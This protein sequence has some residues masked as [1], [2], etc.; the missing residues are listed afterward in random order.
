MTDTRSVELWLDV[1]SAAWAFDDG[2]GHTV[3]TYQCIG[4]NEFPESLGNLADGPVALS[5]PL[6]VRAE[7]G[8]SGSSLPTILIWRGETEFHLTPDVK[9]SNLAYILPFFGRTAP[10]AGCGGRILNTSRWIWSGII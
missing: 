1:L 7:Y 10:T 4:K 8:A 2:R 5:W 9:K 6:A 3:K